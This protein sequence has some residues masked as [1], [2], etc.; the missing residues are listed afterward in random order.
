MIDRIAA[1][2]FAGSAVVMVIAGVMLNRSPDR[3]DVMGAVANARVSPE[4]M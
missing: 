1:V 3:H 4:L 2:I